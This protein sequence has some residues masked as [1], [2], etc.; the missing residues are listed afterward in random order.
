YLTCRHHGIHATYPY[1][2]PAPTL[3]GTLGAFIRIKSPFVNRRELFDVGISGPL[4]GFV[5]AIPAIIAACFLSRETLPAIAP[6]SISVG[7]PLAVI[8]VAKL[9]RSGSPAAGIVL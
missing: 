9:L 5:L 4:A 7:T 6:D 1:F 3:I 8:L 2:I